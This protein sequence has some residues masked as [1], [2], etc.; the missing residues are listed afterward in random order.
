MKS[1]KTRWLLAGLVFLALWPVQGCAPRE[2]LWQAYFDAG[3]KAYV[4]GNY[5]EAE[6]R[7]AEAVKE[8]EGLGDKEPRL[9]TSLN[10][11]AEV[12]RA[13]G[14]YPDA[15]S[16]HKRALAIREKTLGPNHPAVAQSLNNLVEVYRAQG[17]DSEIEP[18]RKRALAIEAE[19]AAQRQLWESYISAGEAAYRQGRYADA[20]EQT[21]AALKAAEAFGSEDPRLATTF[22]NLAEFYRAEGKYAE[23]EPLNK[24]ALAIREKALYQ[25]REF[26]TRGGFPFCYGCDSRLA[27]EIRHVIPISFLLMNI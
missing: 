6:E 9:A 18:F 19:V 11:L 10:G 4:Q 3:A 14:K 24:R 20:V 26:L 8:A 25:R 5:S 12:Y 13:Q 2:G 17:R 27:K 22:N 15:E 16:L 1:H 23:A 21:T 7:F